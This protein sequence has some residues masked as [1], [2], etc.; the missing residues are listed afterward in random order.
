MAA[1]AP[2]V[3]E[4]VVWWALSLGV[5]IISLTIVGGQELLVAVLAALPCGI[6]ATAGRRAAGNAWRVRPGWFTAAALLP[7]A[8]VSDTV[9]VLAT[10]LPGRRTEGSFK[11]IPVAGGVG[12]GPVPAGR[13]AVATILVTLTPG[14]FVT[15]VEPRTG[16]A[17]VHVLTGKPPRIEEAATR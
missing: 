6:L 15:D 1:W 5:W 8:I 7:V 10:A 2:L 12:E 3:V 14:S 4:V 9:Q 11:R 16:Q 13:R 17:L